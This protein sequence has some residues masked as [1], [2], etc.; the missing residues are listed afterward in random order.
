[1]DKSIRVRAR[2]IPQEQFDALSGADREFSL[3]ATWSECWAKILQR[4][5]AWMIERTVWSCKLDWGKYRIV[6]NI[7]LKATRNE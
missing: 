5:P 6:G 7:W 3:W 1:M 4:Y 2:P